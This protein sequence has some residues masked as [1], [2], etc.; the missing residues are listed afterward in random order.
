MWPG[1]VPLRRG[2][3]SAG[4][5]ATMLDL[6]AAVQALDAT[7]SPLEPES[8]PLERARGCVLAEA[9]RADGDLPAADIS[10]MDGYALRRDD[11]NGDEPLPV[12]QEVPAGAAAEPLPAGAAARIFTGA[13]LP[14]GADTVV[15]QELAERL[16]DG[17]VR[18][19]A[20]ERGAHVRRRGELFAAGSILADVGEAVTAQL[21]ALLAAGGGARVRVFRP[22]TVALL[23]TGREVVDPARRPGPGQIR[24][25]NGPMFAALVRAAGCPVACEESVGDE[26]PALRRALEGCLARADV[27]ITSG[28]VSVGDYDL[29]PQV[30]AE[31]EGEVIFHGVAI[32][33]GKPVLAARC[34]ERWLLGLPGNPLASLVGW[35]LFGLPMVR[36]LGGATDPFGAPFRLPLVGDARRAR[37][38]TEVRMGR[39][40][41]GADG[42]GVEVL[43]WKGSHDLTAAAR[44]ETLVRI[45]AGD[46]V[47]EGTPVACYPLEEC[48]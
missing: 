27:V 15:P 23:V 5:D 6:D 22:P 11:L 30:V 28:G 36:R 1:P 12:A 41:R 9:V 26:A 44:A 21:T 13:A 35:R 19:E 7:V 14:A 45:E 18:L 16:D 46:T 32:K 29:V 48:W 24:N 34:G 37:R 3:R 10:A 38:R 8:R 31:L 47:S 39:W 42:L 2:N 25:T 17:R 40:V 33:P 4:Y 43:E 20:L